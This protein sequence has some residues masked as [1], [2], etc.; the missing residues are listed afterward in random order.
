MRVAEAGAG[1]CVESLGAGV[2][3]D[4]EADA[5]VALGGEVTGCCGGG[6]A[7]WEEV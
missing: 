3:G 1:A 5:E 6:G 4:L 2:G 7:E